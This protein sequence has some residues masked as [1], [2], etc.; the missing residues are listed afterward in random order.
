LF[1]DI[2]MK[3]LTVLVIFILCLIVTF[4]DVL[5]AVPAMQ[6]QTE[7]FQPN[8]VAVHVFMRGDEWN[9]WVET[10]EGFVIEKG[11]NGYWCYVTKYEKGKAVLSRIAADKPPPAGLRP[12]LKPSPVK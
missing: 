2:D 8:G 11:L 5:I 10:A 12:G 4:P 7:V 1:K 9:N 6:D 3:M